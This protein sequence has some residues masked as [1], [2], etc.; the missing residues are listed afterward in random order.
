MVSIKLCLDMANRGCVA[1]GAPVSRQT[2][3]AQMRGVTI[4]C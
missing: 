1:Y 4:D 3:E 2:I